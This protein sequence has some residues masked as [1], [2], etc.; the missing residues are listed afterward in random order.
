MSLRSRL[1]R[2]LALFCLTLWLSLTLTPVQAQVSPPPATSLTQQLQ[3]GR[4]YYSSGQ[5]APAAQS[6]R[7]AV[8]AATPN[9]ANQA[10]ALSNLALAHLKLGQY[11]EAEAEIAQAVT[12]ATALADSDYTQRVKAQVFSTQAQIQ[13]AKAQLDQ[14]LASLTQAEAA[15]EAIADTAGLIRTRLNQAQIWRVQGRYR[16]SLDRLEEVRQLLETLPDAA[17]K[18]AGLRQLGNLQR[19]AD[20]IDTSIQTLQASLDVARTAGLEVE[21]SATLLSLGN[22]MA[23]GDTQMAASYYQQA[24]T[25]PVLHTRLQAQINHLQIWLSQPDLTPDQS[26]TVSDLLAQIWA[27]L[28]E[29]PPSRSSILMQA[30]LAQSLIEAASP[31]QLQGAALRDLDIAQL[32]TQVLTQAQALEDVRGQSYALGYLGKLYQKKQQ[33]TE[34]AET[35]QQAL[36]LAQESQANAIT[37]QWQWQLGQ[38]LKSQ[39]NITSAIAAYQE[40]I[41]T[42]QTLRSDL[43]AINPEVRFSFRQGIEPIYRELVDLLLQPEPGAEPSSKNLAVARDVIESLQVAELVNFF[44]ADCLITNPIQIDQ[45]DTQA[46]VIYPIILPDRLEIVVRLPGQEI[47]QHVSVTVSEAKIEQTLDD[48][49][50]AIAIEPP[51]VPVPDAISA[52]VPES[53]P[54]PEL[55]EAEPSARSPRADVDVVTNNEPEPPVDFRPLARQ[56]YEWLIEPI[57]PALEASDTQ[58]LVFVLDGALRNVPMTVL[59]NAQDEYLIEKY[60]IALTPG[61]QLLDP[62]PLTQRRVTAL[63]GGLSQSNQG[64]SGLPYVEA[65]IAKIRAEVP[66]EVLLNQDFNNRDFERTLSDSNF[67]VVHLATHGEFSSDPEDTYILTW[68]GRIQANALGSLLQSSE[69]SRD[70]TVELLILS[71]CET[72]SGDERAA[73]GLAGIAVRSG[74]RSTLASLWQVSDQGTAELM[75]NF[76][77]ELSGSSQT[78]AEILRQAQLKLLQ[79]EDGQ[80]QH[81]YYWA[82][83]VLVGNWL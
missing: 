28:P 46:A 57:A 36:T 79:G 71:A 16:R 59:M 53:P 66:A 70:E 47:L 81:P 77:Q 3:A 19:L 63:V 68:D 6:W 56:V 32:L 54:A 67:R 62:Q 58:V 52:P 15:Y 12:I 7:Q 72:A 74:A 8:Q 45:V 5:Y 82:A 41:K 31:P 11:S 14:A 10:V 21:K 38:I 48:L 9:T 25:S 4:R 60:A 20:S 69:L 17:L 37:Y 64:Y 23:Q 78:K 55:A 73:L 50:E 44:R 40:A 80:Y 42:L 18:A 43:V 75:S 49:R 26:Q 24:A 35:T 29:L 51:E 22:A 33:W 30:S 76:Y 1:V 34:A 13:M 2:F 65:E 39:G 83:F 61:L 27:Q